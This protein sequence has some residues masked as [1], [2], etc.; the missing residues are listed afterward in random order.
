MMEKPQMLSLGE[1]KEEPYASIV[2][3]PKSNAVEVKKR[4]KELAK[5]GVTA[6]EF[7]GEKRVLNVP[8]LGKGC[9]G[10]VVLACRRGKKVALKIRRIDADRVRMRQE[11]ELLQNANSVNVGPKLLDVSE[12]FLLM[13]FI[14]GALLPEWLKTNK[15]HERLRMVLRDVLEQCWRLDNVGLDHG[16]LSHAPKHIIVDVK[17]KPHIVD[18]ESASLNRKSS[19]VT[20]MCQFLFVG[21]EIARIVAEKLG[22]KNK[23]TLVEALR[24]YKNER[25]RE[26]FKRIL[27][28]YE[29]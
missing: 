10:I 12:N 17:G 22:E 27:A 1:L 3:Y 16:E 23:E 29:L 7:V 5:L 2:C 21:S 25:S 24:H 19:N 18:F 20:A 9:V 14:D 4:L 15:E 26:N 28:V 8:V 6:L 13:E 11:A